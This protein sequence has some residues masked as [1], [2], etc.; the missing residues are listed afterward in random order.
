MT[1][2]D[3]SVLH[4]LRSFG[5][6][7]LDRFNDRLRLQKLGYLAQQFGAKGGFPY[8]WYVRGP[9]SSS[10]TSV[11]YQGDE[12]GQ[13]HETPKLTEN[14]TNVVKK[15]QELMGNDVC[16]P[17]QLELYASVL[18]LMPTKPSKENLKIV[19]DVMHQEKPLY[20]DKEISIAFEKIMQLL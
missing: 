15:I 13:F 3:N 11:L 5:E 1:I 7:D 17:R 8:S 9:Y 18:Y 10:L 6:I 4:V 12:L 14:E 20:S 19:L 2:F 16:E